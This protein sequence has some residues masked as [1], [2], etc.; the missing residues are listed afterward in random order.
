[1]KGL[2]RQLKDGGFIRQ[3]DFVLKSGRRSPVYCDI[4][5]AMGNPTLFARMVRALSKE[6]D[7]HVTCIAGAGYGGL[8][9]AAAVAKHMKLPLVMVR[10]Q[11]KD[12]G[13]GRMVEGYHPGP[14]D[15]VGIVDDVYTHGTGMAHIEHVLR[16]R[17]TPVTGRVVV[18]DRSDERDRRVR[19]LMTL[20]DL[21]QTEQEQH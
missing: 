21:F 19:S 13:T 18:V 6:M 11:S 16:K 4:K 2:E 12:H 14:N 15:R 8:P 20:T 10:E 3:G 1:M 7:V 17:N 5:G 9:L